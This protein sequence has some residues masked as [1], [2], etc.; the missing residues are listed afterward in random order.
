[1]E[2][3]CWKVLRGPRGVLEAPDALTPWD[4]AQGA[5]FARFSPVACTNTALLPVFRKPA[6]GPGCPWPGNWDRV[7]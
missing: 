6:P 4:L 3:I 7:P 5:A 1:M 2:M